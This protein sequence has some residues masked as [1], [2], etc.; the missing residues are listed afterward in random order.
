MDEIGKISL[1]LTIG[2]VIG[3]AVALLSIFGG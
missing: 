2:F 3:W 1:I